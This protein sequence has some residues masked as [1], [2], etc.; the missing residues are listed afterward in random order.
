MTDQK[1]PWMLRLLLSSGFISLFSTMFG[2]IFGLYLNNRSTQN[3]LEQTKAAAMQRVFQEIESNEEDLRHYHE[4]LTQ[5]IQPFTYFLTHLDAESSL[6]LIS[7]D[8]LEAFKTQST[9]IFTIEAIKPYSDSLLQVKGELNF[10]VNTPSMIMF[11]GLSDIV[12]E[13]Y[14]QTNALSITSFDCLVQMESLYKIQKEI[15]ELNMQWREA[16]FAKAF[17]GSEK[18]TFLALWENLLIKQKMFLELYN[19]QESLVGMCV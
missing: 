7:K 14:K 6:V 4:I 15:N 13:S 18:E 8:S 5:K 12:W 19:I 3:Q 1:R 17:I 2:V 16:L 9:E 10:N 11:V